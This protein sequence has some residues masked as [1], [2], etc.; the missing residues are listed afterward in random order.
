LKRKSKL[1]LFSRHD[2]NPI[3]TGEDIPGD[4]SLVFNPGAIKFKGKTVLLLRVEG[5]SGYSNVHIAMSKDGISHWNIRKRPLF[6]AN[7]NNPYDEWGCEDSR[8]VHIGNRFFITYTAYS[9]HGP[10]SSIVATKDFKKIEKLGIVLPP[11]NKD[12]TLFSKKI[13]NRW[14]LLH[15]PYGG[16]SQ[17]IWITS[18]KDFRH[19]GNHLC[20]LEKG[21]GNSW[22]S[23]KIG[24]GPPPI[25]TKQGWILIYHGVKE[26]CNTLVYKVGL[27]LLDLDDPTKVIARHKAPIFEAEHDYEMG[28]TAPNV[29]FPT[30]T[31]VQKDTLWLYYGASDSTVC[32]ATARISNLLKLFS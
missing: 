3:I 25:Y 10:V 19:W 1:V 29:V 32:L 7:F 9:H 30:G 14:F 27:A 8:V 6:P 23:L 20:L 16:G 5:S 26:V 18:S 22:D 15:R 11:N 21:K 4:A 13:K 2:D 24:M 31:I 17:D 28:E 12:V